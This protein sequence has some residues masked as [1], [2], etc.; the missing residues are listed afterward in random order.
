MNIKRT[1]AVVIM[2]SILLTALPTL[3]AGKVELSFDCDPS[4]ASIEVIGGKAYLGNYTVPGDGTYPFTATA[5]G[6]MDYNGSFD[7]V[8]GKVYFNGAECGGN[9]I[10]IVMSKQLYPV[11]IT[12]NPQNMTLNVTDSLGNPV[13]D[14]ANLPAGTYLYTAFADGYESAAGKFAVENAPAVVNITLKAIA[15]TTPTTSGIGALALLPANIAGE[16]YSAPTGSPGELV[17]MYLPVIN[18]GEPLTDITI[19][20]I[21]SNNVEEFPFAADAANYGL[22][23]PDLGTGAWAVAQY[24]LKISPYATNGVKT[25]QFRAIYRENGVLRDSTL[26]A[27]VTIVNGYEAPQETLHTAPKL[28]VSGYAV[29]LD[30]IYAGDDF[31]LTVFVK[32]TSASASA[33][34]ITGALTLDPSALMAALGRSD[35]GY[36][37][38]I[39]PGD[40]AEIVYDLTAMPDIQGNAQIAIKL[41]YEDKENTA[42]NV[43]Q[44]ITLPIKQRMRIS[45]DQPEIFA[46]GAAEGDYIAVSLPI[47]NKG[48]TKAYN[49]E[50]KLESEKLSMSESYYGGDILPGAK[51]S[52]EFQLLCLNSGAA[53]GTLTVSFEDAEGNV[54]EQS[55]PIRVDIAESISIPAAADTEAEQPQEKPA[56][57]PIWIAAAG[58]AA[59]IA[60]AA[61]LIIKKGR[62]NAA[63]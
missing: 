14:T 6:Y 34:N 4:T 49:V 57:F 30:T 51:Q 39:A 56:A 28:M 38:K 54:Y 1:I 52:A 7:V 15:K 9:K 47:V 10:H 60:V 12:K 5:D 24:M 50:V 61:A 58:A 31:T 20:P 45:V 37:A 53:D 55:V 11:L 41:E 2:L 46:E 29:N 21:I 62:S 18:N 19:E 59:V 36:A 35:T 48:K 33:V 8:D 27:S 3:A 22:R 44:T 16:Y 42:A 13:S 25:V 26:S 17:S 32:N 23:L 40:T 63:K 43:T